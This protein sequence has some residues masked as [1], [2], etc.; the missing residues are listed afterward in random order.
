MYHT[1]NNDEVRKKTCCIATTILEPTENRCDWDAAKSQPDESAPT[2]NSFKSDVPCLCITG[3]ERKRA[4]S[5]S[6]SMQRPCTLTCSYEYS[7]Y[8]LSIVRTKQDRS[9]HASKLKGSRVT[10]FCPALL[11]H[12]RGKRSL[13]ERNYRGRAC[14]Y[15][16]WRSIA[17]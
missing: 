11:N 12:L 8:V 3:E 13:L 10:V 14:S 5:P 16:V 2:I 4:I 6:V 15:R 7:L 17:R 1:T 9:A